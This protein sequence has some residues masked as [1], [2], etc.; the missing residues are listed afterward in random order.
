MGITMSASSLERTRQLRMAKRDGR[1]A[2]GGFAGFR[3]GGGVDGADAPPR[4]VT[5]PAPASPSSRA[6]VNAVLTDVRN[7]SSD[8][9]LRAD[10]VMPFVACH[11]NTPIGRVLI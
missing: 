6:D 2:F 4:S 1:L 7:L 9:F 8:D 11:A 5:A 10:H 3:P